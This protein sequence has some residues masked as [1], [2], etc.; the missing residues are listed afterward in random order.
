M[1]PIIDVVFGY[2]IRSCDFTDKDEYWWEDNINESEF[3]HTPY[4]GNADDS[5]HCI[6]IVLKSF[7]GIG[8]AENGYECFVWDDQFIPIISIISIISNI[9]E[10]EM[11]KF[12]EFWMTVPN[13]IKEKTFDVPRVFMMFSTS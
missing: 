9:K 1:Y 13:H 6:G 4:H 2:P 8:N 7:D 12:V 3:I 5:P 11:Q 10:P